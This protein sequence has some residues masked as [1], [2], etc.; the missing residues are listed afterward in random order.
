MSEDRDLM[1]FDVLSWVPARR[2]TNGIVQ[3]VGLVLPGTALLVGAGARVARHPDDVP[4][5]LWAAAPVLAVVVLGGWWLLARAGWAPLA[6][7]RA[8]EDAV[9]AHLDRRL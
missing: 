2:S 7:R 9:V 6:A 5:W 1:L 3:L 4:L 8:R